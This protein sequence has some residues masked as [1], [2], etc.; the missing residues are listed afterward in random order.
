MSRASLM[1]MFTIYLIHQLLRHVPPPRKLGAQ[2]RLFYNIQ[3]M[4][5]TLASLIPDEF[6]ISKTMSTLRF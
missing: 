2:E 4:N 1:N 5:F 3:T 6:L